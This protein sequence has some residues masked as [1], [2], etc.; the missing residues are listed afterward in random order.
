M[1][2]LHKLATKSIILYFK[3]N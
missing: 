1:T 3:Y 2:Q